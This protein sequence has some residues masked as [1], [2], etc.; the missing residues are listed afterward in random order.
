M[1]NCYNGY[2]VNNNNSN[3][4]FNP[5]SVSELLPG[6]DAADDWGEDAGGPAPPPAPLRQG[7]RPDIVKIVRA[8]GLQILRQ[9]ISPIFFLSF[10]I[11][12]SKTLDDLIL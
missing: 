9:F 5:V 12:D 1:S 7:A 10:K 3:L 8:V 4:I 11:I 6:P 2:M